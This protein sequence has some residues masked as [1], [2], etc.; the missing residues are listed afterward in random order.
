M[1]KLFAVSCLILNSLV[2][3]PAF[4]EEQP[5]DEPKATCYRLIFQRDGGKAA[6]TYGSRTYQVTGT[7]IESVYFRYSGDKPQ[8]GALTEFHLSESERKTARV[9]PAVSQGAQQ[10]EVAP[11]IQ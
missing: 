10:C 3:A 1:N 8:Q 11:S 9:E 5:E 4:A 2:A 7:I 6:F